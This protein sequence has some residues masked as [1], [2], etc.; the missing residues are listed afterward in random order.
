MKINKRILEELYK[1]Y[2]DL[3]FN[4]KLRKCSLGTFRGKN[5]FGLF[6][7]KRDKNKRI[8]RLRIEIARNV[9]WTEETLRNAL[10]HEM[11]HLY[12]DTTPHPPRRAHGKEFMQVSDELNKR[13]GLHISKR[14]KGL[15]FNDIVIPST[16]IAYIKYWVWR[17][18]L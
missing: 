10:V 17:Y 14:A 5:T 18:I 12:L 8:V 3:Y 9:D 7:Y 4:G 1:R 16:P 11:V 13:Y 6:R 15:E 2:N